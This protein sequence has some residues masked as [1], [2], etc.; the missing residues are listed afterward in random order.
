[1]DVLP[2]WYA[3]LDAGLRVPLAG[4]SGK[5]SNG[6]ALGSMRTYARLRPG[7]EFTYRTWVE[8]V[9]AGRT[10]VS[11]GPLLTLTVDDQDPGTVLARET[12]GVVRVRAEA[13][14]LVPFERLEVIRNGQVV[15]D[16]TA[17]GSPTRAVV[18]AEVPVVEGGWLATRCRGSATVPH[19]PAS[20]R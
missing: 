11:N 5:D 1:F 7:E 9:R 18:E 3:L 2:D 16:A 20:Q 19:R 4:G 15:A 13:R 12:G 14:G 10:F 17:S 8:A 6:I